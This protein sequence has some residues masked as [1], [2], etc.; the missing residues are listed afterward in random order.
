MNAACR[1]AGMRLPA[2][3]DWAT[4]ESRAQ[5]SGLIVAA[6]GAGRFTVNLLGAPRARCQRLDAVCVATGGSA[7]SIAVSCCPTMPIG[8]DCS[9]RFE[10]P[11]RS[12]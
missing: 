2:T 4:I 12:G 9:A 7:V 1:A 6:C 11:A 10:P 5:L 3:R 8:P